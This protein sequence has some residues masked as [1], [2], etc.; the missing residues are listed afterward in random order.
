MQRREQVTEPDSSVSAG[1]ARRVRDS[2]TMASHRAGRSSCCSSGASP[3]SAWSP[4]PRW[5]RRGS[6]P[7]G[8]ASQVRPSPSGTDPRRRRRHL[9]CR[10][11]RSEG[12]GAAVAV[13]LALL[14]VGVVVWRIAAAQADRSAG[15]LLP[16]PAG[17][18]LDQSRS[19]AAPRVSEVGQVSDPAL[20]SQPRTCARSAELSRYSCNPVIA[21]NARPLTSS[22]RLT[23]PASSTARY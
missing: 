8:A 10:R 20:H 16:P 9:P 22:T 3:G 18:R 6:C 12:G 5:V 14:A 1:L 7:R 2:R 21:C 17:F 23:G 4:G 15:A 11:P 13:V 19:T